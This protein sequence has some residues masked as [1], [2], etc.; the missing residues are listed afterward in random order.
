MNTVRITRARR[1]HTLP[2][3]MS[4]IMLEL[5]SSKGDATERDLL[6]EGFKA[7]EIAE[8]GGKARRLAEKSFVKHIDGKAA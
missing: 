5:Y 6:R 8:H 3:T 7:E 2:R 1:D 4:E